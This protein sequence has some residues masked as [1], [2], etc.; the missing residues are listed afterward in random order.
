MSDQKEKRKKRK[1]YRIKI[2]P[3]GEYAPTINYRHIKI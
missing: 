3:S 2:N 1:K